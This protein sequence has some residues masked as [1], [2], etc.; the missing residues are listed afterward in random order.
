MTGRRLP[1]ALA[2][3]S[4]AV[5]LYELLLTRIFSVV[6]LYHFA[7]VA[8][9]LALLGFSVGALIV[10]YRPALYAPERIGDSVARHAAVFA[11]AMLFGTLVLIHFRPPGVDLYAG[12]SVPTLGYLA[13]ACGVA[14][15]PFVAAGVCVSAL[16]AAGR[17]W[18]G[19]YYAYDL[20]GA[21]LGA[22]AF[23]PLVEVCGAPRAIAV[24]AALACGAGL[25]ALGSLRGAAR[26]PLAALAGVALVF[27]AS[28]ETP[29][30]TIRSNKAGQAEDVLYEGWNSFSRVTAIPHGLGNVA[31]LID[32][33]A[34]TTIPSVAAQRRAP[35]DISTPAM[36]LRRGGEILIVGPGGGRD[37]AAASELGLRTIRGVELN[38]MIAELATQRF[39][40]LAGGLYDRPG[41][42]IRVDEGRSF[43]RHD[44]RHY[45]VVLLNMID[46]WAATA[47]GAFALSENNLYTVEA[48]EAFLERLRPDGILSITRWYFPERPYETL[49]LLSLGRA[50][51]A[52]AGIEDPERHV[53]VLRGEAERG[54][55]TFLL[56]KSPF[57]AAE[58]DA[59]RGL[60]REHAD[61]GAVYLPDEPAPSLF[62]ELASSDDPS[63][64]FERYPYD[65]TPPT[66]DRPFYFYVVR[67]RDVLSSF[68][69]DFYRLPNVTNIGVFLLVSSFAID[70]AFVALVLAIPLLVGRGRAAAT[71]GL[72]AALGYFAC[73]GAG[74]M[75]LEIALMQNFVLFLGHPTYALT[76][77]VFVLLLTSG[78][79][80]LAAGRVPPERAQTR[81]AWGLG[82]VVAFGLLAAWGLPALFDA[83]IGWPRPLRIALSGV[84][85]APLGLALG[86]CFPS[87]IRL[88]GERGE[89]LLPWVWAIN[90]CT[91]VLGSALAM[92]IAMNHGFRAAL[93][94][95]VALYALA[96]ALARRLQRAPVG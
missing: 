63:G 61:W 44:E 58:L 85:L 84:V 33:G 86:T 12:L 69:D 73:L 66:D 20:L 5:L 38:P 18:I 2:G 93:L 9:S 65:V 40:E 72:G 17:R 34:S 77:V 14:T 76:V 53:A 71:P 6:L 31:L 89:A 56:K 52:R 81:L 47:A 75:V 55:A 22:L 10:H 54:Q 46:T 94:V 51:L 95:G 8:L 70:L 82:A 30:L 62:R 64:F 19:R 36:H 92:V 88:L 80:S 57:T 23:I 68:R 48:F 7:Y 35:Q 37:V 11:L 83:G 67:A 78:A 50:A 45:D 60:V 32:S 87:G 43:A 15:L 21:A 79:G 24:A 39:R 90:G 4:L 41:V 26:A 25:V 91:S 3:I 1:L 13:M 29:L 42:E 74:F 28:L 59:L 49:R 16:L 27:V 96:F